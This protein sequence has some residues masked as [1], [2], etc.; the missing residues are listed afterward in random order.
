MNIIKTCLDFENKPILSYSFFVENNENNHETL[1]ISS[2][3]EEINFTIELSTHKEY[4]NKYIAIL[5]HNDTNNNDHTLYC[6][7]FEGE[8]KE[9]NSKYILELLKNDD[10]NG[11]MLYKNNLIKAKNIESLIEEF[12]KIIN[13]II[14]DLQIK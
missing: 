12:E 7:S 10:F 8:F 13:I 4:I 1:E 3:E 2:L 9:L 6:F 11:G 5:N 14:S